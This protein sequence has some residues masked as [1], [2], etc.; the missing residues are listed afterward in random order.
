MYIVV[1]SRMTTPVKRYYLR[2]CDQLSS[3]ETT[4]DYQQ[5]ESSGDS[6]INLSDLEFEV[7]DNYIDFNS[8]MASGIHITI[9]PFHGNSGENAKDWV[10]WF[11]NFADAHNFNK[12]KKRQTMPFY[13][14]DHA[15]TWYNAQSPETK[16]DL[17]LLTTGL[18]PDSMA[19]MAWSVIWP[20][21]HCHNSQMSL[22]ITFLQRYLK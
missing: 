20:Y 16:G 1:Y 6:S 15:W 11:N 10:A 4:P 18:R 7:E 9:P 12:N 19:V 17:G 5:E 21:Y 13:L 8:A 14:K 2:L 3:G 22:V